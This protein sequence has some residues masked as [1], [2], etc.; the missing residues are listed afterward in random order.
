MTLGGSETSRLVGRRAAKGG[1]ETENGG[2]SE[3]GGVAY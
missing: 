2:K 1:G 3:I